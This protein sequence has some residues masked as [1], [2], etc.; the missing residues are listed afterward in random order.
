[1]D[2]IAIVVLALIY[3][4]LNI[5]WIIKRDRKYYEIKLRIVYVVVGIALL[6]LMN[7]I[8]NM[9]D[10]FESILLFCTWIVIAVMNEFMYRYMEYK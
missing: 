4:G 10:I 5:A 6:R 9:G 2:K 7:E 1:M 8:V 3:C